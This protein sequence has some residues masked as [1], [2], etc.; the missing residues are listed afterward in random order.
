MKQKKRHHQNKLTKSDNLKGDIAL[1]KSFDDFLSK[2]GHYFLFSL[3]FLI[4]FFVFKDFI[5]LK[6]IYLFKDIGSDTI[7]ISYPMYYSLANYVAKDG[8]PL[9]SF[10]QGMGQNIFPLNLIDPFSLFIIFM[11]K[12]FVYY[13][14]IFAELFK[15]LCAGFFF[16]LFLKKIVVSDYTAIIGGVLYS[17]SGFIVLGGQ[18][19]IFST[20][21]V[22][23]A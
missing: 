7:N 18:W 14:I 12:N 2:Y 1:L 11:G 13:S 8:M 3:I 10:N 21:A 22:Y 15:I 20:Q 6:K 23:V 5:L 19:N 16:F 9:W 4:V 17:F